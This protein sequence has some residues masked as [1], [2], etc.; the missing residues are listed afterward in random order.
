MYNT[1]HSHT[2]SHNLISLHLEAGENTKGIFDGN[3]TEN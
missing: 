3:N 2:L 1:T